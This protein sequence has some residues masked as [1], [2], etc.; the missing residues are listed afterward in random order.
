MVAL[1]ITV[2]NAPEAVT[3]DLALFLTEI[4]VNVFFGDLPRRVLD[5][6]L[7]RLL[8]DLD[9]GGFMEVSWLE[10]SRLHRL[11]FGS[12]LQ[13]RTLTGFPVTTR[14]NTGTHATHHD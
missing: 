13:S 9:E 11:S 4:D 5:R 1:V 12:G 6:L 14:P 7:D 8:D 10:G 2:T 3:G